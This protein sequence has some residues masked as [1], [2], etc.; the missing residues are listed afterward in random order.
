M[1]P[2]FNRDHL[3]RAT[4]GLYSSKYQASGNRALIDGKTGSAD[5]TDGRWQ[6]FEGKDMDVVIDLGREMPV[7]RITASFLQSQSV[8]IF[9]PVEISFSISSDGENYRMMGVSD[10]Y[11]DRSTINDGIKYFESLVYGAPA[12]FVRVNA[13]NIG[14]C[15]RWHQG[16]GRAAWLF[17]DEIMVE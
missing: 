10:N 4:D 5:Y 14:I 1:A 6:G 3:G 7:W 8:W 15:P 16:A 2:P 17:V 9:H 13:K 12:R 11:L